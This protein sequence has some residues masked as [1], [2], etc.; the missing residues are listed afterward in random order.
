MP[1]NIDLHLISKAFP[2]H[3][4]APKDSGVDCCAFSEHWRHPVELT[5]CVALTAAVGVYGKPQTSLSKRDAPL[6]EQTKG[7]IDLRSTAKADKLCNHHQGS[8]P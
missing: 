3:I 1:F 4:H 6:I 8:F 5:R 2:D 7:N